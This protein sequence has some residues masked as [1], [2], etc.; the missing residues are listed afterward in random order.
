ML[1]VRL[2][3]RV[4]LCT[5]ATDMRRSFDSLAGMVQEHL[6][7]DPLSGDLFV[8]RSKRGD[9]VKLLFFEPDGFCL[10]YKRLEEGTFKFPASPQAPGLR[11]AKSVGAQGLHIHA[12]D[13]ALLLEGIDLDSVRR[14]QR[15]RRPAAGTTPATPVTPG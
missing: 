11:E 2:P 3:T 8:F 12:D 10:V 13:L 15:Y 5:L 1:S 7:C 9:R 6:S 14:R 4:Y